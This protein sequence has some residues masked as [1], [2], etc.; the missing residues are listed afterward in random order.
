MKS[1][2][3]ERVISLVTNDYFSVVGVVTDMRRLNSPQDFKVIKVIV[4]CF[5]I[6][7]SN[8]EG[9]VCILM[10]FSTFSIAVVCQMALGQLT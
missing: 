10:S 6:H 5:L 4:S 7:L 3:C 1:V 8:Q 2:F 9:Q